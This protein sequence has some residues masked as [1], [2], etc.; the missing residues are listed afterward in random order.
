MEKFGKSIESTSRYKIV[1][2]L[3]NGQKT[4][5][6]L[7]KIAGLSQPAVSQHLRLL[8]NNNIV[9]NERKGQEIS[10]T[11]NTDYILRILK[12]LSKEVQKQKFYKINQGGNE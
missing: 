3:L 1:E 10:Y 6:E 8:K 2:A 4:V 9:I 5:R 11:I 7:V 12:N